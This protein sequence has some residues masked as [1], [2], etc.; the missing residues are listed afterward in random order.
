MTEILVELVVVVV[1][2]PFR[3][4]FKVEMLP[5]RAKNSIF[6]VEQC[7]IKVADDRFTGK[8]EKRGLSFG[9]HEKGHFPAL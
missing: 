9:N 1:F 4:L 2:I 7:T 8:V 5:F 6:T 3:V